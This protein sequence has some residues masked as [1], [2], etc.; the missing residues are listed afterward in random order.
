MKQ[1]QTLDKLFEQIA[2][3]HFDIETLVTQNSDRHDFH[4]VAVWSIKSALQA[5][6]DAGVAV[7]KKSSPST[8]G[9]T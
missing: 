4:D 8:K 9:T 5:A 1:A 7:A 6:Y 3:E 2:R